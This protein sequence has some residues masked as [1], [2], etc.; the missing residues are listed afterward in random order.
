MIEIE[1]NL[2]FQYNSS[3]KTIILGE[4]IYFSTKIKKMSTNRIFKKFQDRNFVVTDLAMYN[5]KKTELGGR[6]KIEDL[7]AITISETSDQ[8][9]IH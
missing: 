7:K 3:L 6:I 4:K 9:I 8:F 2:N 1:D 5:L